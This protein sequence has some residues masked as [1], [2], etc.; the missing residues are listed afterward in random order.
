MRWLSFP[1]FFSLTVQLLAACGLLIFQTL[2]LADCVTIEEGKLITIQAKICE[3]IQGD[4]NPEVQKY[5]G[6]LYESW[7]LRKAYTGALVLDEQARRWMSP[8]TASNPCAEFPLGK[9]VQKRAYYTCCDSGR[10]GKCVFGGAFLG[11]VDG[12]PLNTFQ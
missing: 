1:R 11:D 9:P 4:T 5:A 10:W 8:S 2:V 3:A 7:N 6:S 12:P